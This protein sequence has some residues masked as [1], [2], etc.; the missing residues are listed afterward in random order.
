M[1][2][3]DL[4]VAPPRSPRAVLDGVTFLP[5]TIDKVR[6]TL[7]GG[8]LG[9]YQIAGL[10]QAQLDALGIPLDAFTAAVA[11]ADDD[12][13]V[14]AFVRERTAPD[15]RERWN[16]RIARWLPRAGNRAEAIAFYPWLAARPDIVLVLDVLEEDDRLHFAALRE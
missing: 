11:A 2:P 3:L 1:T 12:A 7:P 4:T 8:N 5:R 9:A 10:T 15:A 13:A 6:A 14:A 16:E